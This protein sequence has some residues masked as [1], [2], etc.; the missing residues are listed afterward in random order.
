M[1]TKVIILLIIV[2]L[3]TIFVSQN[4]EVITI[5]V[6]LWT[7]N[8]SRIVLISLTLLFGVLIGFIIASMASSSQKKKQ[9]LKEAMRKEKE[10]KN[11]NLNADKSGESKPK[12]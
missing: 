3:F 7:V 9:K 8:M 12:I 6:L 10:M 5:N 2:F 1:K 4:T 11:Q